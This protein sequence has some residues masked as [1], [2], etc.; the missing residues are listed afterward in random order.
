V[1]TCPN[2]GAQVTG[3][4]TKCKTNTRFC[5]ECAEDKNHPAVVVARKVHEHAV[6]GTTYPES[7]MLKDLRGKWAN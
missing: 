4:I 6:A 2:C 1:I 7:E 5:H 3:L